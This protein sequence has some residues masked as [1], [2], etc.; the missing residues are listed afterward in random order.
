MAGKSDS[1][2]QRID[3][4]FVMHSGRSDRW[5]DLA[6]TAR[7]WSDGSKK[8]AD[9]ERARAAISVIETFHAYP[10]ARLLGTLDECIARD[11]AAGAA[12][13]ARRISNSLLTRAYRHRPGEWDP[14]DEMS[15]TSCLRSTAN[16]GLAGHI[17]RSCLSTVSQPRAGRPSPPRSGGSGDLKTRSSM[18]P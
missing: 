7:E 9:V 4:F 18:R 12:A 13:L 3:Q 2:I 10:G 5:R 1:Q 11:D 16:A 15:R 14:N 8:R 17:S 6:H